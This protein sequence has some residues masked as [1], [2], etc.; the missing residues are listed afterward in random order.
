LLD[1]EL[2]DDLG[3]PALALQLL[4]GA[5]TETEQRQDRPYQERA[6]ADL[7]RLSLAH[8]AISDADSY[9]ARLQQLAPD[10]SNWITALLAARLQFAHGD[11]AAALK[12]YMDVLVMR[13]FPEKGRSTSYFARRVL[14]AARMALASGDL[15]AADSLAKHTLRIARNEGHVDSL[16]TVIEG[17]EE[18]QRKLSEDT[19]LTL[20]P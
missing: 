9:L 8:G 11:H 13:G 4:Q 16:S 17:A 12:R 19:A 1:G 7:T 6:L 2:A 3:Q 15:V 18:V 20:K 14:E 5:L 10:S